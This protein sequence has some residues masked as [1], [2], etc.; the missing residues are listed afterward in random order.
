MRLTPSGALLVDGP[1]MKQG[2][3]IVD[4]A[5]LAVYR[6]RNGERVNVTVT[7]RDQVETAMR[8]GNGDD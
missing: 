3:V 5:T 6:L 8:A 2:S 4:D 1:V 7:I